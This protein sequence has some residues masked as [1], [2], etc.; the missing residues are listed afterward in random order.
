MTQDEEKKIS[1]N[2]NPSGTLEITEFIN[3]MAENN[4]PKT[5]DNE[6]KV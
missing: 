1:I 6:K 4:S 2:A 3:R 5:V